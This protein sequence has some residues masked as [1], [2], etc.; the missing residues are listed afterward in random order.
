MLYWKDLKSVRLTLKPDEGVWS[1]AAYDEK[2][3]EKLFRQEIENS[4]W[5]SLDRVSKQLVVVAIDD[6]TLN[7]MDWTW[8]INRSHYAEL[9]DELARQGAETIGLDIL[10]ETR[11]DFPDA[12]Q[13]LKHTL[14]RPE[15]LVPYRIDLSTSSPVIIHPDLQTLQ[16]DQTEEEFARQFVE[17]TGFTQ[18]WSDTD[19]VTRKAALSLEVRGHT[20]YSWDL[21]IASRM[22][23]K[24]PQQ[25]LSALTDVESDTLV[26]R[27]DVEDKNVEVR[28]Q[29]APL[30]LARGARANLKTRDLSDEE[31]GKELLPGV[32]KTDDELDSDRK[33]TLDKILLYVPAVQLWLPLEQGG[34]A[35]Q[36]G[37]MI[38]PQVD[39]QGNV[40]IDPATGQPKPLPC[41]VIVGVTA[42][43]GF[44]RKPTPV[45]PM[46]GLEL[47]AYTIAS[48]LT[49]SF[50]RTPPRLVVGIYFCLCSLLAGLLI[51]TLN[52]R[53]AAALVFLSSGLSIWGT[54]LAYL[55][56]LQ[57]PMLAPVAC[58]A[59]SFMLVNI[60]HV[61]SRTRRIAQ[62]DE[63]I[64]QV[65]NIIRELTPVDTEDLLANNGLKLGGKA[66]E[67]TVLFSDLRGYT[68][69]AEKLQ[70]VEVIDRLNDYFALLGPILERYGGA[71]FDYQGDALMAVFGLKAASQPNHAAAG[72]K[73]SAAI[74]YALEKQR[75]EWLRQGRPMPETGI[76]LCT[77]MVA[78]GGLGT[79]QHKQY[80]AI[81]DPTNTASRMQGKSKELDAPVLIT[82]STFEMAKSDPEVVMRYLEEIEVKGKREPLRVYEVSVDETAQKLALEE[83]PPAEE[84]PVL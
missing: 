64:R 70:S 84:K 74:I 35:G 3:R 25:L 39:A 28:V 21:Q 19:G 72:C 1:F 71:V 2:A 63:R 79:A 10:F 36:V 43:G 44:D 65:Q 18:E 56:Y 42:T 29:Y 69:M 76:G 27:D 20:Y 9:V 40:V 6:S 62:R 55:H 78:F 77:G 41:T 58:M 24:T 81:G 67:L 31:I 49:D 73:A 80:V 45:G 15:V 75:K 33:G 8:P 52:F 14:A 60:F 82:E 26:I 68:S 34:L 46:S 13:S 61:F 83:A 23:G 53:T 38:G 48:I 4:V 22:S 7:T 12:D 16:K 54:K 57:W 51:S 37:G 30:R 59:T 47:H 11:S 32:Y 17:R 50:F 66:T 5:E